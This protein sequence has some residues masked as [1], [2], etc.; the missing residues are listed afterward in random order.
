MLNDDLT[1]VPSMGLPPS[2][3]R[4]TILGGAAVLGTALSLQRL[5]HAV[6]QDASPVA[7]AYPLAG[8]PVIGTWRW[9]NEG[10]TY[11]S[12]GIFVDDG[13]YVETGAGGFVGI[14][15]W[16]ATGERTAELVVN[17]SSAIPL[18]AVFEPRYDIPPETCLVVPWL[19]FG[20]MTVEVDPTGNRITMTGAYEEPDANGDIIKTR[21]IS[22]P[23]DR[24]VLAA[25]T[26][27]PPTA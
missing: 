23:A 12:F 15:I 7:T 16:R 20:R 17:V 18:A 2:L 24:L 22:A 27:A 13:G 1:R 11:I 26:A 6:A 19:G 21:H 8:H 4:R 14:G 3:S 5:S 25:E 10:G 9:A